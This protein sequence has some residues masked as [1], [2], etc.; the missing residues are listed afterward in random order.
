MRQ[1]TV[2]TKAQM[3]HLA[4]AIR[5]AYPMPG[6]ITVHVRTDARTGE[7]VVVVIVP[8]TGQ[9]VVLADPAQPWQTLVE[10]ARQPTS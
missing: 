8:A 5:R 3:D 6:Q 1:G 10:D 9:S 4:A 7:S 2:A